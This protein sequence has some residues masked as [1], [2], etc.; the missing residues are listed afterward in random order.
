[1]IKLNT[2]KPNATAIIGQL[3][4]TGISTTE[5]VV[6]QFGM[7]LSLNSMR[8]W[9]D[10]YT[11]DSRYSIVPLDITVHGVQPI[12]PVAKDVFIEKNRY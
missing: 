9:R 6:I 8:N 10:S 5:I 3:Y 1:M 4:D 12:I 11:A 2:I 7:V